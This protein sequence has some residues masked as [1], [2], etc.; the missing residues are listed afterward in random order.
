M[1]QE[2]QS[3]IFEPFFTTKERGR[4]TGLG[5]A[6]VYGIVKQLGGDIWVDSEPGHGTVFTIYLPKIEQLP[7]PVAAPGRSARNLG[8]EA[9]LL[10]EDETGVR[11]FVRT[12]LERHG[13][14]VLD[15]ASSE[16]ALARLRGHEDPI[17]LL[18]T[19]IMLP[20][21]DG[22][23]LARQL[24]GERPELRVLF[25][26]GYTDPALEHALPPK[27]GF[28]EKPFTAHALLA[29]VRAALDE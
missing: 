26:S 6:A 16:A 18:L 27:A 11:S 4:G 8:T 23:Q 2:V 22:G 20:G 1:T 13:Y 14:R 24:R 28:L 10:V 19:D 7:P 17:D 9:I 3:R 5:L 25:M 15:T 29:R 21:M 12:V